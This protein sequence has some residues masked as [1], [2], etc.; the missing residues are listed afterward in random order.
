MTVIDVDVEKLRVQALYVVYLS[1]R[2]CVCVC[3]S[4]SGIV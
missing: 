3:L 1:D 4:H 2:L